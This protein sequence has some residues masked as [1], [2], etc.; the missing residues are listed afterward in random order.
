MDRMRV[1]GIQILLVNL[2]KT[3]DKLKMDEEIGITFELLVLDDGMEYPLLE[4]VKKLGV[5]VHQLQGVWL[6]KPWDYITYC[7]ALHKFFLEHRD[8]QAIHMN[9]GPKNFFLL[10]YG[11]RVGIP[12]RIAHSH[13]S[14]YQ[15]S[16]RLQKV[17][18]DMFKVPLRSVATHYIACSEKAGRW[19]FGTSLVEQGKVEIL[20]NGVDLEEFRFCKETR[21]QIRKELDIED[22]IVIGNVGRFTM[23]KNHK[24]LIEIFKEI[25]EKN[26]ET[27]L[28]L[29]GIGELMEDC[30]KQ[31]EELGIGESV[32]F[33]GFRSDV[34][35]LLQ[36]MDLFLMP[37]LY[38]GFPVT[39]VEAQASGLPCVFTDT[40]TRE[41]MLLDQVRFLPLDGE[42]KMWAEESLRLQKESQDIQGR[43]NSFQ[44]L[45]DKGFDIEGMANRLNAIYQ[46]K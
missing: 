8:Y 17:L 26:Q 44:V 28:L 46:S 2:M 7:K 42:T 25:H 38:E 32:K 6:R 20:P 11:K 14:G 27:M 19:M 41:A 43:K 39:G 21:E 24:F 33:L 16:S 15:T 31:V 36:A 13:N 1:G 35:D 29:A 40:I 4:E 23:Q 9:S 37:S 18:G 12:I 45:K 34:T 5:R 3:L 22:K 10:W 30:E